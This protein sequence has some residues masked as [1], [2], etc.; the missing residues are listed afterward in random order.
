MSDPND[1]NR[2]AAPGR[3]IPSGLRWSE[4]RPVDG[5]PADVRRPP[6]EAIETF[7]DDVT[8]HAVGP[9]RAAAVQV[10]VP[11]AAPRRPTGPLPVPGAQAGPPPSSQRQAVAPAPP[12][13]FV[14]REPRSWDEVGYDPSFAEQLILRILLDMNVATGRDLSA[15]SCLPMVLVKDVVDSLKTQKFVIH[16]SASAVGDYQSELSDAGRQRAMELRKLTTYIGPAPVPWD[17][18]LKSVHAQALSHQRPTPADLAQAFGDLAVS[19]ELLDRLGPAVTSTRP[20]FLFG[21][22]GNGKTSLAER[23]TKCFGDLIWVP[24]TILIGGQLVKF[25]DQAVHVP[26]EP[27][28]QIDRIDRRWVRIKRPTVIAGGELTLQMLELQ[29]DPFSKLCEPPIQLKANC[30]TLVIDDFGRGNLAP[31]DLLNRWIV[32]LEKRIDFLRLPDGRKQEVP[33][34]CMLVFSTNL[35]PKDLADEAFMRRIP[36]KIRVHD[37]A[38]DEFKGLVESLARKMAIQLPP[39][40]V[41]YLV[42]RHYKMNKRSFRFCH[43]RDLLLQIKHMCTYEEREPIAGTHEWDRVVKNYFGSGA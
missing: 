31:K 17:Q 34:E 22:P 3:K 16:K 25:F 35:E 39:R 37:P 13:S 10:P 14:P 7:S 6:P 2:P 26:V 1:P 24:H 28:T 43:P 5:A 42:D 41:Q 30:G 15:A 18:Y 20:M 33:F 40:S 11:G 38:E 29:L 23:M 9:A 8:E 27:T 12:S 19:E 4:S 21:D 32:P 36:Y